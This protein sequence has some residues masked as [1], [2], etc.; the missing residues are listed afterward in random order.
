MVR[1][2]EYGR[3]L[4]PAELAEEREYRAWLQ[5]V[6]ES[7]SRRVIGGT[8]LTAI[9]GAASAWSI[10]TD[11]SDGY[12]FYGAIVIGLLILGNGVKRRVWPDS[13]DRVTRMRK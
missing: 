5:H 4:S 11:G 6:R 13:V 10:S 7:G 3:E 9:G 12:F 1:V 8:F 2:P